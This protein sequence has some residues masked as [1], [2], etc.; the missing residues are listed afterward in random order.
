[1]NLFLQAFRISFMK[2]VILYYAEC[3]FMPFHINLFLK[4]LISLV[5]SCHYRESLPNVH[6]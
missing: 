6:F 3:I 1:M 2:K 5:L 4:K